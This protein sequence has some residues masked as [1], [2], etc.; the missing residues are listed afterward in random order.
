MLQLIEK[1]A[2]EIIQSVENVFMASRASSFLFSLGLDSILNEDPIYDGIVNSC[3]YNTGL[4]N[5]AFC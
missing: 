1:S 3:C 5:A 2:F 4:P